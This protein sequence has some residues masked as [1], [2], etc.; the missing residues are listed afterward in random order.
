MRGRA[1]MFIFVDFGEKVWYIY[2]V[3]FYV[4]LLFVIEFIVEMSNMKPKLHFF[5]MTTS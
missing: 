1:F 4:F 2:T 3:L 5:V